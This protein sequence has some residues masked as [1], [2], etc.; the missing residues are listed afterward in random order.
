MRG[1]DYLDGYSVELAAK[2]SEVSWGDV[3]W[4]DDPFADLECAS[5]TFVASDMVD[6]CAMFE[7]E[8]DQAYGSYGWGGRF[9]LVD[10]E[11]GGAEAAGG[12]LPGKIRTWKTGI[13][14]SSGTASVASADRFKT[15]WFDDDLNGKIH[16]S[17]TDVTNGRAG[18]NDLYNE[19]GDLNSL[20][21]WKDQ[22]LAPNTNN[23]N[24][25]A[26]IWQDFHDADDDPR[27]GDIGKVDLAGADRSSAAAGN[28]RRNPDGAA[29]NYTADARPCSD[30]DGEGCDAEWSEDYEVLFADGIF[31]CT[32]TRMVTISCEWDAQGQLGNYTRSDHD[33]LVSAG[34]LAIEENYLTAG[35]TGGTYAT[36]PGIDLV[37]P[38]AGLRTPGDWNAFL[39]CTVK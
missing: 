23:L 34:L 10:V 22:A 3:D 35:I 19:N 9:S 21:V 15:V 26:V 31:G 12:N 1:V 8:V 25:L 18:P 38:D 4:K 33:V 36:Y 5:M 24:N 17:P 32:T 7:D 37:D 16:N 20:T 28:D 6:V 29:D 39:K 14:N 27:Y 11:L 2:D 13:W 30:A